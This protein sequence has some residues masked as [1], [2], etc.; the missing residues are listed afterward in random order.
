MLTAFFLLMS[1]SLWSN[2]WSQQPKKAV[3]SGKN[4]PIMLPHWGRQRMVQRAISFYSALHLQHADLQLSKINS[5]DKYR[6]K[7]LCYPG[8]QTAEICHNT[9]AQT[10]RTSPL[11]TLP[12]LISQFVIQDINSLAPSIM[13]MKI[14]QLI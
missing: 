10:S 1:F 2:I 9:M 3:I 4:K 7:H 11:S 6:I 13:Q 8:T 5:A 12:G 14:I